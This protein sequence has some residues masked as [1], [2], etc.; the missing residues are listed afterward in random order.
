MQRLTDSRD[1][2]RYEDVAHLLHGVLLDKTAS[3]LQRSLCSDTAT[4]LFREMSD[5]TSFHALT[6]PRMTASSLI[7]DL[8]CSTITSF[9][10]QNVSLM[11]FNALFFLSACEA[12]A[13]FSIQPY[14]RRRYLTRPDTTLEIQQIGNTF[15]YYLYVLRTWIDGDLRHIKATSTQHPRKGFSE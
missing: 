14:F 4:P 12:A 2:I 1:T 10:H 11:A 5:F 8:M 13:R 7:P 3:Q 9:L 15:H 6:S